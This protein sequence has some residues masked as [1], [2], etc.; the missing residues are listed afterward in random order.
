MDFISLTNQKLEAISY[1][2]M[3][4]NQQASEKIKEFGLVF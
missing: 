2:F 4:S 1:V 3:A